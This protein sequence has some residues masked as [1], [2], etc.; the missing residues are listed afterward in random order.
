MAELNGKQV[1]LVGLK[2]DPGEAGADGK[3]GA[4]GA[5]GATAS[6]GT[7]TGTPS[8]NVTK[9]GTTESPIFNLAFDGLKGAKGDNASGDEVNIIST[10]LN[11]NTIP[12]LSS[13]DFQKATNKDVLCVLNMT[14]PQTG[15]VYTMHRIDIIAGSAGAVFG[16]I[17]I[18]DNKIS[19]YL[20]TVASMSNTVYKIDKEIPE[21][22][23]ANP[24]EEG[25]TDLLKIKIGNAVYNIPEQG[26][27]AS[28]QDGEDGYTFTPSVDSEGNLSW[29]KTQGEGGE[30]PQT[31]N[32]K[33]PKGDT[34]DQGEPGQDAS[35][36][37]GTGTPSVNVTKSGTTE[38]PIFNLAFDGL[39]GAK[40]DPGE[41][42]SGTGGS[43][44]VDT[45]ITLGLLGASGKG[46]SLLQATEEQISLLQQSVIAGN[47]SMIT[48]VPS[49]DCLASQLGLPYDQIKR[50]LLNASMTALGI[51]AKFQLPYMYA[52]NTEDLTELIISGAVSSDD[53]QALYA[54]LFATVDFNIQISINEGLVQWTAE[55]P[56]A[57]NPESIEKKIPIGDVDEDDNWSIAIG[58]ESTVNWN[59]NYSGSHGVAIGNK[60]EVWCYDDNDVG[61]VAI[62]WGAR[63]G[64]EGA[65]AIGGG[66]RA[67]K[68]NTVSFDGYFPDQ[69]PPQNKGI[70]R[71]VE[72]ANPEYLL[73]R[74]QIYNSSGLLEQSGV[75]GNLAEFIC[76]HV[77]ENV[78]AVNGTITR[79]IEEL[80][81]YT[82][83][84]FKDETG[85]IYTVKSVKISG[86]TATISLVD[87]TFSGNGELTCYR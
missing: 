43:S 56:N 57:E 33:G 29:T 40:G 3:D 75:S 14:D 21:K 18:L 2:G 34:G 32:I 85:N 47:P 8:V 72:I 26:S 25:S 11:E 68:A 64:K 71:Y 42:G 30:V 12:A 50:V 65:V 46:Q 51:S 82:R 35:V 41:S 70:T 23:T 83:F 61:G 69:N 36:G 38:S 31:V 17:N 76:G 54:Y 37:T 80:S 4:A 78:S 74:G 49:D 52:I 53:E 66:A 58:R 39:K 48:I 67:E 63:A 20:V 22:V 6:V 5:T 84:V 16:V 1:I 81:K 55:S 79:E 59:H 24:S 44:V 45:G 9:S 87:D 73:F 60:A 27:G 86:N 10:T 15:T 13:E 28:G 7:G 19:G 77:E 62:G